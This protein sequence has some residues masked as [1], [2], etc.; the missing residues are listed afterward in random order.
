MA[1]HLL[2]APGNT[3][4]GDAGP[5]EADGTGWMRER[6]AGPGRIVERTRLRPDGRIE[7]VFDFDSVD[8]L[9][10]APLLRRDC[11]YRQ[12]AGGGFEFSMELPAAADFAPPAA[13]G[14]APVAGRTPANAEIRIRA[15]GRI[16]SHN[17]DG[18]IERGNVVVWRRPA[19]GRAAADSA[20]GDTLRV[21]TDG[22]SVFAYT[23][24]TVGR[25]ALIALAVVGASLALLV[26][27]GRRRLRRTAPEGGPGGGD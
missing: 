6:L 13:G 25:S 27:E 19:E 18:P 10:S 22:A 26:F 15:E 20:P 7:G 12:T 3:D 8:A 14:S 2:P 24:R 11:R 23:A 5:G 1:P 9:C 17:G 16:I 4:S 21:R